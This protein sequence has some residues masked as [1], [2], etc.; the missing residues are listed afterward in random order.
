MYRTSSNPST[1]SFSFRSIQAVRD[2]V[3]GSN[4]NS[5]GPSPKLFSVVVV[6]VVAVYLLLLSLYVGF[7]VGSLLWSL[8]FWCLSIFEIILLRKRELIALL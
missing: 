3:T 2:V 1:S 5:Q 4:K 7:C 6:F 8:L